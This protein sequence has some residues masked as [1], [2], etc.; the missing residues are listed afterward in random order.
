MVDK[1]VYIIPGRETVI[2]GGTRQ[3]GDADLNVRASDRD[4][5]WETACKYIPS[6]KDA[7]WEW[8][9]VG[10]RPFR[11]PLRLESEIVHFHSGSLP[12]IHNY[13]HSGEGVGLAWGTAKH[14]CRLVCELVTASTPAMAKL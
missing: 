9:W 8:E 1:D 14:A 12:V 4:R 5:I 7:K 13:G 10:L 6:L 2:V 3:Q 11:N